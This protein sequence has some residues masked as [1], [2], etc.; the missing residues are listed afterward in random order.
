V[1]TELVPRGILLA[2]AD[3]AHV[4]VRFGDPE[5]LSELQLKLLDK[6]DRATLRSAVLGDAPLFFNSVMEAGDPRRICCLAPIFALLSVLPGARGKILR[7]EQATD[8]TGTVS[9]ASV[10]LWGD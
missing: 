9:Y 7:Y 5:P 4:G 1:L 10:G 2:G 6:K 8:A 3:L